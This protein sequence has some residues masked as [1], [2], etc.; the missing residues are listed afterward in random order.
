MSSQQPIGRRSVGQ[1]LAEAASEIRAGSVRLVVGG[2]VSL[3]LIL[4]CW[5]LLITV[6][7]VSDF[8]AKG[9]RDVYTYLVTDPVAP[10]YREEMFSALLET[11]GHAGIGFAAGGLAAV[12]CAL[13]LLWYPTAELSVMPFALT[14]RTVPIIAMTPVIALVFGRGL[15]G[16]TVVAGI[17]TFLPTLVN[18]TA[19]LRSASKTSLDVLHAYGAGRLTVLRKVQLPSA[20]PALFASARLAAPAAVSGALL[21]EFLVTGNGIGTLMLTTISTSDYI[22]LWSAV[23]VVTTAS[24]VL[25]AIVAGLESQAL[26]RY[27]PGHGRQVH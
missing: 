18:V 6:S 25:Y 13:M 1:R 15:L 10:R 16:V 11:L 9:P 12:L 4:I 23:F 2:V 3:A 20:M 14:I 24:V 22:R 5:Q 7:Q 21:A 17:V 19:G 27:A 8:I 26:R